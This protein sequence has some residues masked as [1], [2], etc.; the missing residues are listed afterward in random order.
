MSPVIQSFKTCNLFVVTDMYILAIIR[1]QLKITK[2]TAEV[3]Y[4]KKTV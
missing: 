4:N 3:T 2:I 1:V